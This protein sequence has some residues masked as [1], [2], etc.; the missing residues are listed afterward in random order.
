MKCE[1][2]N[3]TIDSEEAYHEHLRIRHADELDEDEASRIADESDRKR[4]IS[5]GVPI[6]AVVLVT[7]IGFGLLAVG[8]DFAG[9]SSDSGSTTAASSE[10]AKYTPTDIGSRHVHGQITVVVEGTEI[11]F[12]KRQYQLQDEA[13]HMEQEGDERWHIHAQNVTLE[14][15]IN[16]F[17]GL[18]IGSGS[19]TYDG[20][21]YRDS[22][23]GTTVE[24]T[25]NGEPVDPI[26]YVIQKGDD[27]RIAVRTS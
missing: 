25:V 17:P 27:I 13:F 16:T 2:C 6:L 18:E 14:Y 11:D 4:W 19:V 5:A 23:P 12:G 21:T 9:L 10:S 20:T 22:A 15:A 26:T 3:R 24:I 1:Y 8:A 7:A